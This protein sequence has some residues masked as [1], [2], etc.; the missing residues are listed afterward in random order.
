MRKFLSGFLASSAMLLLL[1][2]MSGC[3]N[4]TDTSVSQQVFEIAWL[5][6]ESGMLAY[7]DKVTISS[8]DG[9]QIDG[10]NL[11]HVG[12][13]GSIGNSMNPADAAQNPS[14]YAP[15]VSVSADGNAA[16]ASFINGVGLPDI[17]R[18][19]LS[20]GNVTDIIQSTYLLGVS[21][22]LHYAATTTLSAG[23]P[24]RLVELYDLNSLQPLLPKQTIPGAA[25]NRVLWIDGTHYAITIQ[26]TLGA[27]NAPRFHVA[28][29]NTAG[30]ITE[31]IPNAN[32]PFHASAYAPK[33]G[34]LFVQTYREGIDKINLTTSIR[35]SVITNDSVSSMDVSSDGTLL[36]YSSDAPS[37][38][39]TYPAYAVNVANGHRSNIGSGVI[40][41]ILSPNADK[42]A[43]IHQISGGASSDIQVVG[44]TLPN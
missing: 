19:D 35:T 5:P 7:I 34:D 6:N 21:P 15:I 16:V 38:N 10:Q 23:Y 32:V 36:V 12:S 33:S 14:G 22:D 2:A 43:F 1:S 24:Y 17:Y 44:V 25:S 3:S 40:A 9:S 13:D 8:L 11:Y 39:A 28:I 18:Y 30:E 4:T 27:D 31:V 29:Y 41:P 37:N 42:V 26:D 20:G